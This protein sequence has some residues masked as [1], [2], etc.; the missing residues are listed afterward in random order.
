MM[1]TA[2]LRNYCSPTLL[3]N[4]MWRWGEERSVVRR[5]ERRAIMRPE[6]LVFHPCQAPISKVLLY[7][8]GV[9]G[10]KWK[11]G[12]GTGEEES[13][14][15]LLT[16]FC[17]PQTRLLLHTTPCISTPALITRTAIKS[18]QLAASDCTPAAGKAMFICMTWSYSLS[19]SPLPHSASRNLAWMHVC[20]YIAAD[21]GIKSG[22]GGGRVWW[23]L[24]SSWMW[25]MQM[26]G[27]L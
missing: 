19:Q 22:G 20:W 14:R 2:R 21:R 5:R 11:K 27:S 13:E 17:F 12:M 1:S 10:I 8:L 9:A 24:T 26:W 15:Y 6:W 16:C 7:L 4:W 23:V 3:I 25:N 18:K